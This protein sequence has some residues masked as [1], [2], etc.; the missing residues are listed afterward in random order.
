MNSQEK[1]KPTPKVKGLP[2]V[3][4]LFDL[5]PS[6]RF[7]FLNRTM[8]CGDVAEFRAGPRVVSMINSGTIGYAMMTN[9]AQFLQGGVNH[10]IAESTGPYSLMALD[11]DIHK[12]LRKIAAPAFSPKRIS[13]YAALMVGRAQQMVSGWKN[14]EPIFVA[15]YMQELMANMMAKAL[16]NLD[17]LE[18]NGVFDAMKQGLDY[19]DYLVTHPIRFPKS[20]P[21]PRNVRAHR[22]L[23][24]GRQLVQE[25]INYYRKTREATGDML[26]TMLLAVVDKQDIKP[27][28]LDV[29]LIDTIFNI[30]GGSLD[31][32][33]TTLTWTWL[34]L[35]QHPEIYERL[36]TEVDTVLQGRLPTH[37]DLEK[38][39]YLLQVLKEGQR[40]YPS[41]YLVGRVAVQDAEIEGYFFP[42]G[43]ESAINLYG[44]HHN[45]RYFPSPERFDPER[46]SAEN[47]PKL[48]KGAF[49]PFGAGP[50][51]CI[52]AHFTMIAAPLVMAT[53]LQ[54]VTF[55]LPPGPPITPKAAFLLKPP[56]L[57]L[58]VR[59]REGK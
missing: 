44:C 27:E 21:T 15:D 10:D 34:M 18:G 35:C 7:D 29:W 49:I 54:R 40:I 2:V 6:R 46:F 12:E 14:G 43:R 11:G 57:Q 1:T 52:G 19:V 41:A 22:A 30:F 23:A 53:I 45:P 8:E 50:H 3:G 16:F 4:S 55:E 13:E 58:K 5:L 39:P 48:P 25:R 38:M 33:P 9:P 17:H 42:K 36:R 37:A 28:L 59:L 31:T 26:S 20:W 32:T 56:R 51:Y 24:R 47:E